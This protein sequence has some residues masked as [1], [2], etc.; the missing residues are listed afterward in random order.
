MVAELQY[1][2]EENSG[3]RQIL[4]TYP[5]ILSAHLLAIGLFLN[6]S[7]WAEESYV[8]GLLRT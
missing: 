1:S 3:F 4:Q 2:E 5:H 7:L 6:Q 8:E